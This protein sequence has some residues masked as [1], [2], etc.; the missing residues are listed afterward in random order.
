MCVCVWQHLVSQDPLV[1]VAGYGQRGRKRSAGVQ[2]VRT[3]KHAHYCWEA[4]TAS[5]ADM[6][7][8]FDFPW[9]SE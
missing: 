3:C 5:A 2:W 6:R 8:L 9:V 4:T 1:C 7:S